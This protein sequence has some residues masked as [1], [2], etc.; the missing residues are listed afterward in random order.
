MQKAE[1]NINYPN[2]LLYMSYSVYSKYI[3]IYQLSIYLSKSTVWYSE[4]MR[5]EQAFCINFSTVH[6]QVCWINYCVMDTSLFAPL[7]VYLREI[8][9]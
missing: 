3:S 1:Q 8:F 2:E 5:H 7:N 6:R 9:V 4:E